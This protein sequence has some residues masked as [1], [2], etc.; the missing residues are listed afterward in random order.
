MNAPM[1]GQY[2][3]EP[4]EVN[5]EVTVIIPDSFFVALGPAPDD[6]SKKYP[7]LCMM[8]GGDWITFP[9]KTVKQMDEIIADMIDARERT[10]GPK[11]EPK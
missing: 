8:I 5:K 9:C 4:L 1:K 7:L 10:F 6:L 11:E 2:K 3:P